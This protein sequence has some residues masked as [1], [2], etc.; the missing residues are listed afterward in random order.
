MSASRIRLNIICDSCTNS[1]KNCTDY[2]Q[3]KESFTVFAI[4]LGEHA[5]IMNARRFSVWAEGKH[6]F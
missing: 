1:H 4:K 3:S 2:Q 6:M 5:N